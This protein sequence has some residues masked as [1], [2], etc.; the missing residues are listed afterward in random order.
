MTST[1]K[2]DRHAEHPELAVVRR[3]GMLVGLIPLNSPELPEWSR[4]IPQDVLLDSPQRVVASTT[5]QLLMERGER[6]TPKVA[7]AFRQKVEAASSAQED[8]QPSP[9]EDDAAVAETLLIMQQGDAG[10]RK[11]KVPE[12]D[13]LAES[14]VSLLAFVF[15]ICN[16]RTYPGA[17]TLDKSNRCSAGWP[18]VTSKSLWKTVEGSQTEVH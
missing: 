6:V 14:L 3:N 10:S 8:A 16:S 13:L 7:L 18:W 5:I 12:P 15:D 11:R 9:A 2:I 4:D 17:Q 1:L